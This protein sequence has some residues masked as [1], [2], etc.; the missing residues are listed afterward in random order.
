MKRVLLF[1]TLV[2]AGS[3]WTASK[4]ICLVSKAPAL[5]QYI[6]VQGTLE[7]AG[8]PCETW[9]DCMDC[10]TPVLVANDKTYY[11]TTKDKNIE[12]QLDSLVTLPMTVNCVCTVSAVLKGLPYTQGSFDYLDVVEIESSTDL[13]EVPYGDHHRDTI[14]LNKETET[15]TNDDPG[16]STVDPVD[17]TQVVAVLNGNSLSIEEASGTYTQVTV[18]NSDPKNVIKRTMSFRSSISILLAYPD[19]YTLVLSN[20]KWDY[21]ISGTFTYA[22]QGIESIQSSDINIKKILRNGQLLIQQ[23]ENVYTI[24]GTPLQ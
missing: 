7:Y 6:S 8:Y 20:S 16:S 10:G 2:L 22:P 4:A 23:G 11:L 12:R 17:P 13:E 9:E 21:T 15:D 18:T 19:T 5:E 14:P 1:V 3:V 24:L